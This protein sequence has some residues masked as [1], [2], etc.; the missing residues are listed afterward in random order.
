VTSV[1]LE[2]RVAAPIERVWEVFTDLDRAP[3]NLTAVSGIQRHD[4]GPF[5]E[6]TT[7]RETRRMYGRDYTETL[8]VT[9]CRPPERYVVEAN[10][11][12]AHYATEFVFT[13]VDA[14]TTAV[15]VRFRAEGTN[16]AVRLFDRLLGGMMSASVRKTLRRDLDELAAAAESGSS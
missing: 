6:G 1:E 7:W 5:G 14:G 16:A 3:A 15:R 9:V 11:P 4:D 8:T 13:P 12:G 10:S 2:R